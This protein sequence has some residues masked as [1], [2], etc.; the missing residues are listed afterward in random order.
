M[1]RPTTAADKSAGVFYGWKI[2]AA[3]FATLM[4]TAGLGFYNVAVILVAARTELGASV[5]AVS[6]GPALFF[7]ISGIAGYALS[8]WMDDVDLRWFY[9]AGAITGAAALLGLRWVDS[10]AT[11]YVFFVL[12]G[13]GFALAGLVPGITLVARWFTVRRSIA[14]S[15]ASTGLSMGGI[16][17]T[18]FASTLIDQRDLGGAGPIMAIAWLIG[19]M[20]PAAILRSFPADKGLQPDG[21]AA[22]VGTVEVDG[23]TFAA[24]KRTRLFQFLAA[25]YALVFLAQVGGLAHLANLG[26]ERVDR[27]TGAA[28]ISLLA[29]SSIIGRLIGGVVV[30]KIPA[31]ELSGVLILVQAAAL[32]LLAFANGRSGIL[33]ASALFGLSVGNL[34]MLQ[35]LLL[36]E[37]FGVRN[38]SQIYAYSQLIAT[39]G[40]A[41][42]PFLIG[43]LRDLIDYRFAFIASAV[44]NFAAF[45]LL[46]AGGP[47]KRAIAEWAP[48]QT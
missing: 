1:T 39:I 37:A 26:A 28:A 27:A 42:G 7:G 48:A 35:P 20:A 11:L 45:G 41:A 8:K 15:V 4:V 21:A 18:P 14:L 16:V 43:A 44:V 13:V 17:I 19:V 25:V 40:V 22:P 31:R 38:Y 47:V 46:L 36:V 9:L 30:T 3:V 23:A 32:V 10:V 34:L 33:V 12:F 29:L 6:F 24:A 2:V 5:S